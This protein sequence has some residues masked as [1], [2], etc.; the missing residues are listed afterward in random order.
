MKSK[1]SS[2]MNPHNKISNNNKVLPIEDNN[3]RV[4]VTEGII[5]RS[6]KYTLNYILY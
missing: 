2:L 4:V 3:H 6:S 5:I 1:S